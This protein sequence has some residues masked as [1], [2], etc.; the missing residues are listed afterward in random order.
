MI[1]DA[2]MDLW[3]WG[4]GFNQWVTKPYSKASKVPHELDYLRGIHNT[5][6]LSTLAEWLTKKVGFDVRLRTMW[7][8]KY[9]YVKPVAG[10]VRELADIAVIVQKIVPDDGHSKVISRTMWLLQAKVASAP[11]VAFTGHSSKKEIELFEGT[12][13]A[14]TPQFQVLSSLVGSPLMPIFP[15]GAFNGPKH[16]SFMTLH[17]DPKVPVQDAVRERWT[18][19]RTV[20]PVNGSF[21]ASL[22]E[23]INGIKGMPVKLPVQPGDHWSALFKLLMTYAQVKPTIRHAISAMNSTGAVMQFSTLQ[24]AAIE[25][26]YRDRYKN[27]AGSLNFWRK[28]SNGI[29]SIRRSRYAGR[30]TTWQGLDRMLRTEAFEDSR[31][32]PDAPYSIESLEPINPSPGVPLI[33]FIDLADRH[34]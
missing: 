6:A 27:M 30:N 16:W 33:L 32:P 11:N 17:R 23:V 14:P 20:L 4:R 28:S 13:P 2:E 8:D 5:P 15:A 9:V 25:T 12:P 22:I 21:C 18:G 7:Q 1:S 34:G 10:N 19:S 24:H 3:L 29:P 26:V 31:P